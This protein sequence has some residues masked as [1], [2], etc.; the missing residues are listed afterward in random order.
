MRSN[1][2]RTKCFRLLFWEL[3]S[4]ATIDKSNGRPWL[5]N[6]I[7]IR[8]YDHIDVKHV[9]VCLKPK[10]FLHA[11]ISDRSS[12]NYSKIRFT[13]ERIFHGDRGEKPWMFGVWQKF[14]KTTTI[15]LKAAA[16][17]SF[18]IHL[19]SL[20]HH[21]ICFSFNKY[22]CCRTAFKAAIKCGLWLGYNSFQPGWKTA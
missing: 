16:T 4:R 7:K 17:T 3:K 1:K 2:C 5:G 14:H 20:K 19:H 10:T 22:L 12:N 18:S 9:C 6:E 15:S 8:N 21:K 11:S 13:R